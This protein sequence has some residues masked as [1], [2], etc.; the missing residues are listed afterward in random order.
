MLFVITLSVFVIVVLDLKELGV[1]K[2]I[3]GR[4]SG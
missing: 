3:G 4:V 1:I 2:V